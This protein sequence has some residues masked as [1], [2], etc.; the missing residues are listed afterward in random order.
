M[1]DAL[2]HAIM[3]KVLMKMIKGCNAEYLT[4]IMVK[5]ADAFLKHLERPFKEVSHNPE[6]LFSLIR[7]KTFIMSYFEIM[8][9]RLKS[10]T[11]KSVIHKRIYGGEA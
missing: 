5:Y 6:V 8:Y 2:R 11:I 1:D 7:E 4:E 10:D 3:Q 9:R